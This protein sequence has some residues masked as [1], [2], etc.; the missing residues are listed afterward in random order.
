MKAKECISQV[1]DKV[2]EEFETGLEY[3]TGGIRWQDK[4]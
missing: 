3:K 4:Y 2:V 1:W